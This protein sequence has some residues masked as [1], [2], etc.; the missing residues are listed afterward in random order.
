MIDKE[1]KEK[2]E[3]LARDYGLGLVLLFGSAVSGRTHQGSDIDIAVL[4]GDLGTARAR[5]IDLSVDLQEIFSDRETD[6]ALIDGADPLFLKKILENC[7]LLFG[8]QRTLAELRM[9]A[10]KRYIDHKRY[11]KMEGEYV[12][13]LLD[14]FEK[15]AA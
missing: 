11:L 10:Y 7:E 4:F 3:K 12:K 1:K 2:V 15:G 13:R 6:L 5:V 8:E 14:R 9:Y